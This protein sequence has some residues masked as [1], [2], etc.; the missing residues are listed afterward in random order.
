M[1]SLDKACEPTS[2]FTFSKCLPIMR[3]LSNRNMRFP[4]TL[5]IHNFIKLWNTW[6]KVRY[7]FV[8]KPLNSIWNSFNLVLRLFHVWTCLMRHWFGTDL[9]NAIKLIPIYR[10]IN[11]IVFEALYGKEFYY[12][13]NRLLLTSNLMCCYGLQFK[14]C[15]VFTYAYAF[16]VQFVLAV[17]NPQL[18]HYTFIR[19]VPNS[20]ECERSFSKC[21]LARAGNKGRIVRKL[22]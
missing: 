7:D 15:L 18:V 9:I 17:F 12:S 10:S 13:Y 22:F 6:C 16:T 21:G 1:F 11:W 4:Y 19:V 5:D 14:A 8:V 2:V 3:I 20:T